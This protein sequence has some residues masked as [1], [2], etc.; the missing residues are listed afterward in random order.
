M[1]PGFPGN[2]PPTIGACAALT[3]GRTNARRIRGRV[4]AQFRP[5]RHRRLYVTVSIDGQKF[6]L[7]RR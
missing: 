7:P 4:L 5:S 2:K 3:R 6:T 1:S